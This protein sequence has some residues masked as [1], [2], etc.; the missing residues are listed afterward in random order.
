MLTLLLP[1][2]QTR[3]VLPLVRTAPQHQSIL[4]PDTAPG[5]V[6]PGIL[7]CLSE[8][9]AFGIC[10]EDVDGTVIGQMPVHLLERCQKELVKFRITHVVV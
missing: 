8:V 1:T 5:Q 9:Q 4:L 2:I 3:L 7:E 10:M 6:E